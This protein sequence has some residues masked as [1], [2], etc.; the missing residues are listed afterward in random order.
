MSKSKEEILAESYGVLVEYLKLHIGYSAVERITEAMESYANQQTANLTERL[1]ITESNLSREKK[2]YERVLGEKEEA[3]AGLKGVL[4]RIKNGDYV[5]VDAESALIEI[6][7]I[8]QQ[9]IT[10]L[11]I[12][13]DD[14]K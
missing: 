8:I 10:K 2:M 11:N 14:Q 5:A 7:N 12:N 4:L 6:D 3:I 13:E 1:A 9:S